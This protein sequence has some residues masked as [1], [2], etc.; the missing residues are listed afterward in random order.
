MG[1]SGPLPPAGGRHG[2]GRAR[3]A[4][5]RRRAAAVVQGYTPLARRPPK[6][7]PAAHLSL[8]V[9]FPPAPTRHAALIGVGLGLAVLQELVAR[10]MERLPGHGM[11]RSRWSGRR[12]GAGPPPPTRGRMCS[13]SSRRCAGR[14][15][16]GCA[17]PGARP[18]RAT[19]RRPRPRRWRRLS[20]GRLWLSPAIVACA[21]PARPVPQRPRD[22]RRWRQTMCWYWATT[23]RPACWPPRRPIACG[24]ADGRSRQGYAPMPQGRAGGGEAVAWTTLIAALEELLARIT[25]RRRDP[26]RFSLTVYSSSEPLVAAFRA[27]APGA[28]TSRRQAQA[29]LARFGATSVVWQPPR[30]AGVLAGGGGRGIARRPAG[31]NPAAPFVV[32]VLVHRGLERWIA[33]RT[34]G[35]RNRTAPL[36][37]GRREFLKRLAGLAAGVVARPL[38]S[39]GATAVGGSPPARRLLPSLRPRRWDPMRYMCCGPPTGRR[40]RPRRWRRWACPRLAAGQAR[41][42][43]SQLQQ[44]RSAAR[45]DPPGHVTRPGDALAGLGRR[46]HYVG[47]AQRHGRH[48][49]GAAQPGRAR[50]S[51]HA[52]LSR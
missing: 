37:L 23:R 43:E 47:G 15:R 32:A 30:V 14:C 24:R 7:D 44:R 28:P 4:G 41:G 50:A 19:A 38:L 5:G 36:V 21:N 49:P 12:P 13:G 52:R 45:L 16:A 9:P 17:W 8:A 11:D 2:G 40:R 25:A 42:A 27:T 3:R 20:P 29:L 51:Q 34:T 33:W 1:G 18:R 39:P 6:P 35:Q 10:G 46:P 48:P 22:R 26:A 31:M